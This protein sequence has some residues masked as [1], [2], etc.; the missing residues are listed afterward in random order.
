MEDKRERVIDEIYEDPEKIVDELGVP[1]DEDAVSH[2]GFRDAQEFVNYVFDTISLQPEDAG[3]V[4][5]YIEGP[6]CPY[7][8]HL[9]D[10][11]DPALDSFQDVEEAEPQFR[12]DKD[13]ARHEFTELFCD[14]H[15]DAWIS[16]Y[17]KTYHDE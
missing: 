3:R 13:V 5:E 16:Y 6:R 14:T 4:V 1:D 17:E 9:E 15:F 10:D 7:C 2:Y 8:E 12:E 11:K